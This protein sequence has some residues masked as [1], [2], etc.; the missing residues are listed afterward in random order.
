MLKAVGQCGELS[1]H[2][3]YHHSELWLLLFKSQ[4]LANN[5]PEKA[6][7][8]GPIAWTP[9]IQQTLADQDAWSNHLENKLEDERYFYPYSPTFCLSNKTIFTYILK[10]KISIKI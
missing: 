5:P 7:D 2:L 6:A 3:R 8:D 1:C 4:L 9:A 10:Y